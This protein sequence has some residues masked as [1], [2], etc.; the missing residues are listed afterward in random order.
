LIPGEEGASNPADDR[1]VEAVAKAWQTAMAGIAYMPFSADEIRARF[2]RLAASALEAVAASGAAEAAARRGRAIAG[3]LIE[4]NLLKPEAL[5]RTLICLSQELAGVAPPQRIASL[6]AGLAGGF[7]AAVE[8]TLLAHQ[9][10]IGRAATVALERA[11]VEL[12]SSR[13]SLTAANRE[14]SAQIEE[15]VRAEEAA[16]DYAE[17][18][19]RL[20][21]IDLAVLSA[22]SLSAIADISI[23][24]VQGQIP[25]L[26]VWFALFD[27]VN[28]QSIILSSN[29]AN[30]PIGRKFAITQVDALQVMEEGNTFY[31][32][33]LQAVRERSSALAELADM[34]GRSLMAVPLYNRGE[35]IGALVVVLDEI[36]PFTQA[37][38]IVAREITDSIAVAIENRR[39]L[40]AEQAARERETTLREVAA[41]LTQGLDLD[42]VLHGILDQLDRV[43]ASRSSAILLLD[44]GRPVVASQRGA[45]IT[46]EQADLL[47]TVKPRSIWGILE[48]SEPRIINDTRGS[49]DWFTLDGLEYIRSWLGVPLLV[50]GECIGVL[51]IDRDRPDAFNAQDMEL[52]LTFANQAAIAIENAR[53]FRRQQNYAEELEA[54]VRDRTHELEVL[55]AISNAA[56]GQADMESMLRRSLELAL[57]AFG[58]S[59]GAIYLAE[60]EES[61]LQLVACCDRHN[62]V[63]AEFLRGLTGESPYLIGPQRSG[64]TLLKATPDLPGDWRAAG[65][66]TY[67]VAPLRSLN[68]TMGV[69][70]L[71]CDRS[72]CFSAASLPLLT[73]IADQI[74][75][76]AENFELRRLS[77]QAA[78]IEERERL[79]GDLHDVVTQTI[80][81]ACLFAEATREAIQ[82][83]NLPKARQHVRSVL[84]LTDQALRELR[85]LL[86]ELRTE[87]L[88][89]KGLASALQE[90]LQMVER[91]AGIRAGVKAA[92]MKT[93]LPTILEDT[94]YRVALEALNNAL[95]HARATQ[96]EVIL[97]AEDSD[98]VM[99]IVDDGVGFDQN[100]AYGEGGMGLEGM[101]KRI[102]KVGGAI[103]LTSSPG[104]G[105]HIT[106]RA[107]LAPGSL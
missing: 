17:R 80:Y 59:A 91:R 63:L 72:D 43:I 78:I 100:A 50:K 34:G 32:P 52:A 79:A 15:R 16:R 88:A 2:R 21:E 10:S 62:P 105:T 26:C 27:L 66:T 69:I 9:E 3:G 20:H 18:L 31:L 75:A 41:S 81:S 82:A 30:F 107:P 25:A 54:R 11:R 28:N 45:H 55:Y 68:R 101:K 24:Y 42:E 106:V 64:V 46:P 12:E 29:N 5:E 49:P 89:R 39:L 4:L 67:A 23:A 71:L 56:I 53:L 90:R 94:F 22:E 73:T 33:D 51:N 104:V 13:D 86:F 35:L 102:E 70:G 76:A 47:L 84:R 93:R 60:G 96:V 19:K 74:G 85:L 65:A 14:L 97:A 83:K 87:T 95:R 98:L 40:E 8:T 1:R 103:K 61:K 57:E 38:L 37:E 44:G 7:A 58:S 48:D 77:R 36:R 6:L 92:E 99:V